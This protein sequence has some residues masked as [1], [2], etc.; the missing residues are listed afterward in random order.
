[1]L[2]THD[3]WLMCTVSGNQQWICFLDA[4]HLCG[5]NAQP[6]AQHEQILHSIWFESPH[7]VDVES[8]ASI[9]NESHALHCFPNE[10]ILALAASQ[11]VGLAQAGGRIIAWGN[12]DRFGFAV[13]GAFNSFCTVCRIRPILRVVWNTVGARRHLN[14]TAFSPRCSLH[15]F[16]LR[17]TVLSGNWVDY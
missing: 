2:L 10:A 13:A 1:M 12:Q 3:C 16:H 7:I 6:N 15:T 11:T 9:L 8:W 4:K 5:G 14:C 17:R